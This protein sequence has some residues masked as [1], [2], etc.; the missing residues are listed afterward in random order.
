[1]APAAELSTFNTEVAPFRAE[2]V[3][4]WVT[5]IKFAV[6]PATGANA[7]GVVLS[8]IPVQLPPGVVLPAGGATVTTVVLTVSSPVAVELV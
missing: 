6:A 1:M 4:S 5:K 7:P 8:T 2:I 3:P